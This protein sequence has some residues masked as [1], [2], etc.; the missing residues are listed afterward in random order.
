LEEFIS[1]FIDSMRTYIFEGFSLFL[2]SICT[3]LLL[4]N[5]AINR[6]VQAI[7]GLAQILI[8]VTLAFI[9]YNHPVEM[10]RGADTLTQEISGEV[11]QGPYNAVNGGEA[12]ET[13]MEGKVSALVWNLMVHK[14]WQIAEFGSVAKSKTYETDILKYEP[15]SEQRKELVEKL[16][17]EQGLFSKSG[18]FQLERIM[19]LIVVGFLNLIIFL[20]L[21]A[22]CVLIVGYQFLILLYMLLGIFVFLLA[23][24]PY[25]SIELVK[26][27]GYRI[28]S[29][30]AT[31]ILLAFFLS[32][33]LVFMDAMYKFTDTKGLLF[34]MFMI[35]VI[36][37]MIY[38]KR[39]DILSLFTDFRAGNMSVAG[40]YQSMNHAMD[41]DL[42]M[43]D[44]LTS[45]GNM[46]KTEHSTQETPTAK[47]GSSQ[48]NMTSSASSEKRSKEAS[49]ESEAKMKEVAGAI[50]KSTQDMSRY[51]RKAE[52]LLQKQ[53]EKSK[54]ESEETAERKGSEPEYGEF[55]RRTNAVRSLGAGPFEQRDISSVARI[56]QRVEKS[57]GDIDQVVVGSEADLSEEVRRPANLFDKS[58]NS[59]KRTLGDTSGPASNQKGIK[60]GI[61]YF[62]ET[63]GEEKGEEFYSSMSQKYDAATGN[64]FGSPDRL[65]DAQV[66]RQLK[67]R[68][69][70]EKQNKATTGI[71]N[72]KQDNK[73]RPAIKMRGTED[74]GEEE[75]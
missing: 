59:E 36:I 70:E 38:I 64:S 10:M 7:S 22:F 55:V 13:S 52:E 3:L 45:F 49:F 12:S 43:V 60:H 15:E 1:P 31:K 26:R 35:I 50:T 2:I 54:A 61:D 9:F 48:R 8:V 75:K 17:E 71:N 41:R 46:R 44:N 23:L 73:S 28:L 34:T 33:L 65:T 58:T 74:R 5:L 21:T 68:E 30:C 40:A 51:L 47:A 27:W 18:A 20:F 37:A 72:I 66:Q 24:I 62:K 25:F 32:L 53:Y 42:N 69:R 11:L 63:F 39:K 29:V 6:Q 57:G 56:L 16:A 19:V 4:I 67:D 14:P